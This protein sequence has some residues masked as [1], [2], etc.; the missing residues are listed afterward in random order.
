[1]LSVYGSLSRKR[2][3]SVGDPQAWRGL[4][5]A[6]Q[7]LA[8]Q[9]AGKLDQAEAASEY[10]NGLEILKRGLTRFDQSLATNQDW[11]KYPDLAA[12]AED[13]L[14][15]EAFAAVKNQTALNNLQT[16]WTSMRDSHLASVAGMQDSMRTNILYGDFTKRGIE[17]LNN[18]GKSLAQKIADQ[19]VDTSQADSAGIISHAAAVQYMDTFKYNAEIGD[20]TT[21]ADQVSQSLG[22][23]TALTWI[24]D[25]GADYQNL[26]AA[27]KQG[28]ARTISANDTMRRASY[29]RKAKDSNNKLASQVNEFFAK[30]D[31]GGAQGFLNKNVNSFMDEEGGAAGADTWQKWNERVRSEV[32][33][34]EQNRAYVRSLGEQAHGGF[35]T[36]AAN[37]LSVQMADPNSTV[38]AKYDLLRQ[39]VTPGKDANGKVIP[40]AISLDDRKKLMAQIKNSSTVIHDSLGLL[41]GM[42]KKDAEGNPGPLTADDVKIGQSMVQEMVDKSPDMTPTKIQEETQKIADYLQAKAV[43]AAIANVKWNQATVLQTEKMVEE[44]GF[45]YI[46]KTTEGAK[47]LN[48]L[49]KEQ[50][51]ELA[52]RGITAAPVG[53]IAGNP[54]F[55]SDGT[56]NGT[57]YYFD[58]SSGQPVLKKQV[59]VLQGGTTSVKKWV[60]LK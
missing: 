45:A 49:A 58:A 2:R 48:A 37:T 35:D 5:N 46:A 53:V 42:S 9:V 16:A 4:G 28:V 60:I 1:M 15:K 27:A 54:L 6:L 34:Q 55:S 11:Q 50:T 41:D 3:H 31:M 12:K 43:R 18:P 56:R 29:N 8:F 59:D 13:Q 32:R 38:E 14:Q 36:E 21:K 19:T 57:L 33:A 47:V 24:A 52:K 40:P 22:L 51:T 30:D 39:G 17:N 10:N 25:H 26:D 23:D 44:P 7:G 20:M